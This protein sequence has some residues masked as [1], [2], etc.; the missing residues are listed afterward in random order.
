MSEVMEPLERWATL[1][2]LIV[3]Q[4]IKHW[5]SVRGKGKKNG[6]RMWLH[7]RS[8][9]LRTDS[10]WLIHWSNLPTVAQRSNNSIAFFISSLC[11]F[12]HPSLTFNIS[13]MILSPF[14]SLSSDPVRSYFSSLSLSLTLSL[15]L[16]HLI[17]FCY[18]RH[19]P[20][21]FSMYIYL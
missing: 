7:R 12:I 1:G 18:V 9:W 20:A 21:L 17:F 14:F 16:Y 15:S 8:F 3:S 19:S 6:E 11:I 5:L 4:C 13:N 10:Q 2:Q